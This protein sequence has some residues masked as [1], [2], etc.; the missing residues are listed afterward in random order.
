MGRGDTGGVGHWQADGAG[1]AIPARPCAAGQGGA[2]VIWGLQPVTLVLDQAPC[3]SG[4]H[5]GGQ[6]SPCVGAGAGASMRIAHPAAARAGLPLQALEHALCTR[7]RHTPD[8]P[9]VSPLTVKA[10]LE[11]R[12]ALAKVGMRPRRRSPI[13]ALL[14]TRWRGVKRAWAERGGST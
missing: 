11:N 5:V 12:D 8:G 10:A 4:L 7:T 14:A 13:G 2:C 6:R 3:S 9:I 1:P